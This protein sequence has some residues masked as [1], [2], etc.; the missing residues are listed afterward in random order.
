MA[1]AT[2]EKRPTDV[3]RMFDAVATRYDAMNA[4]MTLGQERRWRRAVAREVG[5]RPGLRVLDL[6]A[7]TGASSR[8]FAAAGATTVACDFSLG[9]LTVGRARHPDQLYV[10]GDALR[11]PFGDGAFDAVTISFG[12]RNV[13][14]VGAALRELARVTRPGGRL[15][16]LETSTPPTRLLRVVHDAYVERVLPLIARVVASSPDAYAY[17]A[18]SVGVWLDQHALAEAIRAAG[19]TS[20]RWRDLMLGTVAIHSATRPG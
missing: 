7:G 13:V 17:L 6:A 5:A 15:V 10:A 16:I 3:A 19:W 18:E 1:R 9:M 11:L 2:L 12:L 4:V 8:P 14:D 20:V